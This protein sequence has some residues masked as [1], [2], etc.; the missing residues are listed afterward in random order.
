MQK[1]LKSLPDGAGPVDGLGP[2]ALSEADRRD[3]S[4]MVHR[5]RG[6]VPNPLAAPRLQITAATRVMSRAIVLDAEAQAEEDLA[7][8]AIVD[9]SR[10][11]PRSEMLCRMYFVIQYTAP[12]EW[13]VYQ[14][15]EPPESKTPE[16]TKLDS[17]T[18]KSAKGTFLILILLL[19]QPLFFLDAQSDLY[20]ILAV[21]ALHVSHVSPPCSG[22]IVKLGLVQETPIIELLER[23]SAK[24]LIGLDSHAVVVASDEWRCPDCTVINKNVFVRCSVCDYFEFRNQVTTTTTTT[25]INKS[26]G[27]GGGDRKISGNDRKISGSDDKS[28]KSSK[29]SGSDSKPSCGNVPPPPPPAGRMPLHDESWQCN[30]CTFVNT[31][32]MMLCQV[33]G[34]D[35]VPF[36][37]STFDDLEWPEFGRRN[38]PS[39]PLAIVN[40]F[41]GAAPL[42]SSTSSGNLSR[43][44]PLPSST[45]A[46]AAATATPSATTASAPLLEVVEQLKLTDSFEAEMARAAAVSLAAASPVS[47]LTPAVKQMSIVEPDQWMTDTND[48]LVMALMRGSSE[49]PLPRPPPPRRAPLSSVSEGKKS[50]LVY[51]PEQDK[52]LPG[53]SVYVPCER[54]RNWD[55]EYD[56]YAAAIAADASDVCMNVGCCVSTPCARCRYDYK[57]SRQ[58]HRPKKERKPRRYVDQKEKCVNPSC[59]YLVPCARCLVLNCEG[60]WPS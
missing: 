26:N 56:K 15:C 20:G 4:W 51:V 52:C 27:D 10:P 44:I 14:H 42:P 45:T 43:S 37:S 22:R 59:T 19:T 40:E 12:N 13:V 5:Q 17:S 16:Q 18:T 23:I 54:C 33:C 55:R 9:A 38:M 50:G 3:L 36:P 24:S 31:K 2:V 25:T 7:C 48:P 8:S 34:M 29:I 60:N 11:T 6:G 39:L 41:K 49:L 35:R 30:A 46:A 53:C 21:D 32:W 28:G 58:H 47:S 1:F 57:F